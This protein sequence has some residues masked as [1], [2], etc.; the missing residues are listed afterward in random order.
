MKVLDKPSS[1]AVVRFRAEC[2]ALKAIKCAELKVAAPRCPPHVWPCPWFFWHCHQELWCH[3]LY[4]VCDFRP[5][6][7]H[8]LPEFGGLLDEIIKVAVDGG[9]TDP[10][11][12]GMPIEFVQEITIQM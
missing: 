3:H 7:C 1:A 9:L 4:L 5:V 2:G 12:Q 8:V 10:V 6:K 11:K